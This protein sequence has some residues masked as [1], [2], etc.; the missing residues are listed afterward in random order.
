MWKSCVKLCKENLAF[1]GQGGKARIVYFIHNVSLQSDVSM[2]LA[3]YALLFVITG[4]FL[5]KIKALEHEKE[6]NS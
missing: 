6:F 3:E 2:Q 4:I 5:I 1:S